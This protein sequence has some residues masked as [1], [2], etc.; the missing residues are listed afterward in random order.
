MRAR[1]IS[2]VLL[3]VMVSVPSGEASAGAVLRSSDGA[4]NLFP[5]QVTVTVRVSAQVETT[6]MVLGFAPLPS[7]GSH[8]LTVPSPP[9]AYPVGAPEVFRPH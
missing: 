6:T 9:G 5:E 7:R 2:A 1:D 4:G 3:V 8:V